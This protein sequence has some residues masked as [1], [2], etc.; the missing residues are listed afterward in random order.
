MAA[1]RCSGAA[2]STSVCARRGGLRQ[3]LFA[4]AQPSSG[5][6][7]RTLTL[8]VF[9]PDKTALRVVLSGEGSNTRAVVEFI[10]R[11]SPQPGSRDVH[12]THQKNFSVAG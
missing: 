10:E 5:R 12:L 3:A 4:H 11:L 1:A 8:L 7:T 6:L 9:Q 2:T